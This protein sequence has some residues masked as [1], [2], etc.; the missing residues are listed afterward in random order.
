MATEFLP[1]PTI[2]R[3]SFSQYSQSTVSA[4]SS[5]F[6]TDWGSYFGGTAPQL[7]ATTA[8]PTQ[9]IL[10]VPNGPTLYINNGVARTP[11]DGVTTNGS[12]TVTSA[13]AFFNASDLYAS[14]SGTG[15]PASS[16]I[17]AV[18]SAT[19]VTI[20]ANATATGS[21]VSITVTRVGGDWV[22]GTYGTWQVIPAYLMGRTVADGATTNAST[23]VTSAT[24]AFTSRDVG[25]VIATTNLPVGTTIVSVT[26]ATT[27]VVSAAATATGSSQAVT[28]TP[29]ASLFT[30]D[31]V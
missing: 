20:S 8:Q 4:F 31:I 9:A 26:N 23:T 28:L 24:A 3:Y 12:A 13:T 18:N 14:I 7:L 16:T 29:V 10:I 6:N 11:T 25:G 21:G 17:V 15:I 5:A 2:K 22:G 30:P 27:V 1:S 19:S